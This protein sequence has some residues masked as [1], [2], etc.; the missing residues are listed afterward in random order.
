[1]EFILKNSKGF[2]SGVLTIILH[3]SFLICIHCKNFIMDCIDSPLFN[4][5]LYKYPFS[6]KLYIK[7]I[8]ILIT[9]IKSLFFI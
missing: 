2:D 6:F 4:I 7:E 5:D 8:A 1:M 3:Y 9:I